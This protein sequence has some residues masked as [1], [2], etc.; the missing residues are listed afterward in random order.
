V[1]EKKS[2]IY[3]IE[4]LI[5][6]KKYIGRGINVENRMGQN[7]KGC[8]I[9]Y[10]A[11]KK[12]GKNNFKRYVIEYYDNVEILGLMETYFIV[13]YRSHVS[14]WGYN[15]SWGG[16]SMFGVKHTQEWK[17]NNSK[18]MSG[19]NHPLYGKFGKDN[20]NYGYRATEETRKKLSKA[21][22]GSKNGMYG[23]H[24]SEEQ[25]RNF[26]ENYSGEN[27]PNWGKKSPSAT[28][29]YFGVSKT[30]SHKKYHYWQSY[31]RGKF[32]GEC[33]NEIDAARI[34]DEYIINNNLPGILNFPKNYPNRTIKN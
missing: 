22:S 26:S 12:Y 34:H 3:C 16:S 15:I 17:D 2:G 20:P 18:R 1:K 6:G 23:K 4:N 28:S 5:N 29:K 25:K 13:F 14:E 31:Y 8:K 21:S 24:N 19:K 27:H 10:R 32:L 33:K 11:I 9:L 30:T 7:H